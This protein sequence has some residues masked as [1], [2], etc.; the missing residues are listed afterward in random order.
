MKGWGPEI[1]LSLGLAL[2]AAVW[3]LHE[4]P[5]E[6]AWTSPATGPDLEP[7]STDSWG[8]LISSESMGP[9][10]N[11]FERRIGPYRLLPPGAVGEPDALDHAW[12]V[13][14]PERAWAGLDHRARA[15]LQALTRRRGVVLVEAPPPNAGIPD[16]WLVLGARL[17]EQTD[18][19]AG[20]PSLP[21]SGFV[22][23]PW[24]D[25]VELS[26]LRRVAERLPVVSWWPFP[27]ESLGALVLSYDGQGLGERA[28]WMPRHDAA[29]GGTGT[30]FMAPLPDAA[31]PPKGIDCGLWWTRPGDDPVVRRFDGLGPLRLH[32]QVVSLPDQVA[33]LAGLCGTEPSAVRTYRTGG[34][35]PALVGMI[36]AA[37]VGID[38]SLGPADSTSARGYVHGTGL[39]FHPLDRSGRAFDL[40]EVPYHL[41]DTA[42]PGDLDSML[43]ASEQGHHQMVH[44]VLRARSMVL[45]ARGPKIRAWLDLP[46][47]ARAHHHV[48]W[49]ISRAVAHWRARIASPL[50][51]EVSPGRDL[52]VV[53]ARPVGRGLTLAVPAAYLGHRL[54]GLQVDGSPRP[55]G[56]LA[57]TSALYLVPL[58]AGEHEVRLSYGPAEDAGRLGGRPVG[59]SPGSSEASGSPGR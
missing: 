33:M 57:R 27:G 55:T 59:D 20:P 48:L 7:R 8:V 18:P 2:A 51:F 49:S 38:S 1:L 12:F 9:W 14:I 53:R 24:M 15:N 44:V 42:G 36:A 28:L 22:E 47:Q 54:Q 45:A 11:W 50:A 4:H 41:L 31:P 26:I 25:M 5:L 40:Y 52:V 17:G 30:L 34:D 37:R 10:I 23:E 29:R 43:S 3:N 16:D 21:G 6:R 35:W 19:L 58:E 56:S 46:G 32:G 13:V 39:P